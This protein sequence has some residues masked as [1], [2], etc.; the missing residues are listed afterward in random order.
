LLDRIRSYKQLR[1]AIPQA[2]HTECAWV[3]TLDIAAETSNVDLVR[4]SEL[5]NLRRFHIAI[6]NNEATVDE[7][8]N[9]SVLPG[10]HHGV[11]AGPTFCFPGIG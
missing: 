5:R 11:F 2:I 1:L 4:V 9:I 3:T 7:G 10:R 6:T 8:V